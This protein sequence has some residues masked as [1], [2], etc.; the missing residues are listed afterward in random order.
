MARRKKVHPIIRQIK[1]RLSQINTLKRTARMLGV[2][3]SE[4]T[5][6]AFSPEMKRTLRKGKRELQAQTQ[7]SFAPPPALPPAPAPQPASRPRRR[8]RSGDVSPGELEQL[9]G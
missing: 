8:A 1:Q 4:L 5:P 3:L 9:I 2:D 6:V 7:A